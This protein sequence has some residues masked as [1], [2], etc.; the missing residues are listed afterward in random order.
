MKTKT[1]TAIAVINAGNLKGHNMYICNDCQRK[2][3][4]PLIKFV[5][6]CWWKGDAEICPYCYSYDIDEIPDEDE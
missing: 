3:S 2:F 1:S 5:S 4:E 6:N